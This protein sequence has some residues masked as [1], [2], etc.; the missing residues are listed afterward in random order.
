MPSG[1]QVFL[2]L[3]FHINGP[4]VKHFFNDVFVLENTEGGKITLGVQLS[5]IICIP[6]LGRC[7]SKFN[8]ARFIALG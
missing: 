1:D 7:L 8:S 5:L 6:L 4:F 2:R 3:S